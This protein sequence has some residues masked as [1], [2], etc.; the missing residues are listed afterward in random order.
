[1]NRPI[2]VLLVEDNPGDVDLICELLTD[3]GVS[4]D[5]TVASD[6][7]EAVNILVGNGKGGAGERPHMIVLDLN[8][9]KKDGRQVLAIIKSEHSLQ[10]I[11]VVILSSSDAEKDVINSYQ[12]G[13]N[14]YIKKPDDLPS[15]REAVGVLEKFWFVIAKLPPREDSAAATR[16]G[17]GL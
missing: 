11:P 2:K 16:I 9:P 4:V 7:I 8:L 6:G 3:S 13:A 5:V 14:C 17:A 15:Y 12:L 10:R 1:M